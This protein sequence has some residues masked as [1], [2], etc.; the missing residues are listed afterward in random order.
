MHYLDESHILLFL[1]QVFILMACA[2]GFGE[3]LRRWK[4]PALTAEILVGIVLGPTI[5]GRFLPGF[6]QALFPHE[7]IQQTMLD[8]LAWVGV[9]FLLLDAGLELDFSI[10]WRQRSSTLVIALSDIIVPMIVAFAAVVWLPARYMVDPDRRVIF[11]LFMA[12][13]M[14]ISAMP[15]AVRVLHDLKILKTNMGFLVMSAL[16]VND[17]IGWVLFSIILGIFTS[18]NVALGPIALV[19]AATIG[20]ATFALTLGRRL[21]TS[22]FDSLKRRN[23]PEP[24]TS[25]TIVVLLGLLFGIF[26]QK[27]GI[28]ALFGFFI[29]G[30]VVGEAKSLSE[31]TRS[32]ISQIVHSLFVPLFFANIGLKIDF[33]ANFD[34]FLV[35]LMC[36]AG[37]GGRYLG[38][39]LGVT[40]TN[41]PRINRDL[42]AIAHTPGG[43]MEVVVALLALQAG[44]I[45]PAVFVAIVFSA[46]F[47]SMLMG[48]WMAKSMARRVA[49][50]PAQFLIPNAILADLKATT[51]GD[52]ISMLVARVDPR[53]GAVRQSQITD[54]AMVRERDLG[55]AIGD[56]IAIPH[57]RIKG[58]T[59]P[60]LAYGRSLEGLDWDAPDGGPVFHVFFL[61]TPVETADLHVQILASIATAMELPENRQELSEAPDAPA[62]FRT[63]SIL[64]A[65]KKPE[66]QPDKALDGDK[67]THTGARFPH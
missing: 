61:A 45:T 4:Q 10:A 39:W 20:F 31:K 55:T 28:H 48:L 26:T 6:Q 62:L 29:A 59:N 15:V 11:S 41:V 54:G 52:A 51:R 58:L 65:M 22:V 19:F 64:L 23:F 12:T 34:L 18:G 14:T 7:A 47:S 42:I 50:S 1:V 66:R 46:I 57:V 2:R 3:L 17:I 56:G 49:A 38:A 36:V 27:L 40:W 53:L 63:L 33:A 30:I 32:V 21:S 35:T 13:V 9:L 16:A 5:L 44:L 37:I 8:T 24:G 60:V 25:L 43:M 67:N